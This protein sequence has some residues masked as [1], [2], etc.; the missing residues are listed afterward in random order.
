MKI[1]PLALSLVAVM[2]AAS[3]HAGND[4]NYGDPTASY[5]GIGIQQTNDAT[6]VSGVFG[7]GQHI[8]QLEGTFGEGHAFSYRARYF[9]VDQASGFGVSFDLLGHH[10]DQTDALGGL[11]GVV[12]KFEVTPNIMVV[13]ML[14][15]GYAEASLMLKQTEITADSVVVQPG[16]YIMYGFDAGHWLYAN[17]KSTYVHE[18]KKASAE[19]EIGGGYMV[20]ENAS[21]GFKYDLSHFQGKTDHKGWVNAYY[22]F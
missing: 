7:T 17:P 12:Q 2:G 3:A 8:G 14:A 6:M 13:P 10:D 15:A 5:R 4:V 20:L 18:L 1:T 19:L 16:V 11:V 22:Y 9:N 21:V